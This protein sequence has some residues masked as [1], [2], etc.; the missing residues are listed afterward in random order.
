VT[1]AV[2][3]GVAAAVAAL[4]DWWA[5]DRDR[6]RLGYAAKPAVLVLLVA[7]AVL[8]EPADPTVRAWFVAGLVA[9][10]VGDVVLMLP[11]GPFVGGLGAFLVAHLCYVA[12]FVVHGPSA[13]WSAVGVGVAVV[14]VAVVG[15]GLVR[16]VAARDRRLVA[17]VVAYVGAIS[18]MVVLAVGTGQA[19]AAVGA[20]WFFASDAIL[21]WTRF[22][23]GFPHDRLAVHVT[24]HLGQAMLVA[25][26]AA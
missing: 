21:G 24:Y 11:R 16:G 22:V 18:V 7:A 9:S 8:L 20:L 19:L 13:G 3:C 10:L 6:V 14:A 17:P 12:G 4:L 5:V 26:L 1:G 2:V 25:W 15:P 23:R